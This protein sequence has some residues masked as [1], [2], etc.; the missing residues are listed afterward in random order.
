MG[1]LVATLCV[2]MAGAQGSSWLDLYESRGYFVLPHLVDAER[3][4]EMSERVLAHLRATGEAHKY[5][6]NG[7]KLGGWFIPGIER[8]AA[9]RD[10]EHE[11]AHDER[12]AK[13]LSAILGDDFALLERSEI[14][15]SRVGNW[16]ADDLYGAFDLYSNH[17]SFVSDLWCPGGGRAPALPPMVRPNVRGRKAPFATDDE[18]CAA[19]LEFGFGKGT[20]FWAEDRGEARRV[21]TVGL[22]LED[23]G[24]DDGG[25]SIAP[26]THANATRHA[27]VLARLDPYDPRHRPEAETPYDQ[28]HSRPGDAVVFDS[29][30]IHRGARETYADHERTG[31][32]RR[33][34]VSFSFGRRNA[35]SEA[36]SRGMRFRTDMLVNASICADERAKFAHGDPDFGSPCAFDAVRED[37]RRRPM[38]GVPDG[39]PWLQTRRTLARQQHHHRGGGRAAFAAS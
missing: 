9:L 6:M 13:L 35:L 33:T 12:L 2:V 38:R 14:Y 30:L 16:H 25:L 22:Y 26:H 39:E 18:V 8:I 19:G 3:V 32:N 23:H 29:R 7:K 15:V 27:D 37:L 24:F 36:F 34:V 4:A 20:T 21:T 17:L 31:T 10:F 5:M 28:I 11:I 1:R